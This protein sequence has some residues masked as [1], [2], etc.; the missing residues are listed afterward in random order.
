MLTDRSTHSKPHLPTRQLLYS[1][2]HEQ[3][4]SFTLILIRVDQGVSMENPSL[5][6]SVQK[7]ITF[8]IRPTSGN[9]GVDGS[10]GTPASRS[11]FPVNHNDVYVM[12][13]M[14]S[15][16]DGWKPGQFDRIV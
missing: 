4:I 6:S 12:D 13:D 10:L 15:E 11:R 2:T 16:R 14:G 1:L 8:A 7:P 3:P 9:T 5:H